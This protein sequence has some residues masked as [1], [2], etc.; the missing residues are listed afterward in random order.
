M[1]NKFDVKFLNGV[2]LSTE[3]VVKRC[4]IKNVFL[5]ISFRKIHR[6][7]P[8]AGVFLGI[9]RNFKEHL[10]Y[11]TP[12]VAAPVSSVTKGKMVKS[13]SKTI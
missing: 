9:F 5:E 8:C 7:I 10:F 4:S 2:L 3:A 13:L 12:L 11:R 6:K 1:E